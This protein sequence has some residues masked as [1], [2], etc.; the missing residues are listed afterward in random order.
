MWMH[1]RLAKTSEIQ[2]VDRYLKRLKLVYD[3]LVE[4]LV[5]MLLRPLA[6]S[7]G[8]EKTG[9]VAVAS[10]FNLYHSWISG[11]VRI[12]YDSAEQV[13]VLC[14]YRHFEPTIWSISV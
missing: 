9:S 10:Q 7:V 8:T 13:F 6:P 3:F 11:S 4:R 5:Q 12:F 14:V 1:H 2:P